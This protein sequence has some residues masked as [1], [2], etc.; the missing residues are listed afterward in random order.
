MRIGFISQK[1]ALL[2]KNEIR[3]KKQHQK[4]R[5][6]E[7]K[8]EMWITCGVFRSSSMEKWREVELSSPT[9]AYKLIPLYI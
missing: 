6:R 1:K 5:S 9:S 8:E 7:T 2:L 4:I 3:G